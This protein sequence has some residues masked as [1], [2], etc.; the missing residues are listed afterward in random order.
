MKLVR[1]YSADQ[2]SALVEILRSGGDVSSSELIGMKML[3]SILKRYEGMTAL[4]FSRGSQ[5]A[6]SFIARDVGGAVRQA[7]QSAVRVDYLV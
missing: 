6:L 1:S 2:V 4:D 5:P 3:V 7:H